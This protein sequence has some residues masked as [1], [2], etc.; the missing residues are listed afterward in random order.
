MPLTRTTVTMAATTGTT[1]RT[2]TPLAADF[3]ELISFRALSTGDTSARI[4]ITD[5]DSRIVFLDAADVDYTSIKSRKPGLDDTVTV[6]TLA[7][8]GDVT[9][10]AATLGSGQGIPVKSPLQID[11]SNGTA[12]DTLTL[13]LYYRYPLYKATTTL[14]VPNPAA[15]V[16]NTV[17][18]RS[19]FAQVLGYKALLTGTDTAVRLQI[20]DADSRTVYLDAADKDYKTAAIH[21]LFTTD[22]TATGITDVPVD[23]TGAAATATAVFAPAVVRSPLSVSIVNG[24]TAADSIAVDLYYRV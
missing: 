13:D 17:T 7:A 14:V 21:K 5:G 12:G 20:A 4:K 15:T 1:G 16:T 19:K 6:L 8:L 3:A 24:G 9:G 11:W 18:L 23:A 22:D 10:A 2:T